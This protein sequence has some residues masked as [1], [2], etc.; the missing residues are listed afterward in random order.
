[1]ALSTTGRPDIIGRWINSG[2]KALPVIDD[3]PAFVG[4]WKRWWG[5]LQPKS[6][7]QKGNGKGSRGVDDKEEWEDLR[8]GSINGFFNIVVSLASWWMALKTAAQRKIFLEMIDEVSW[9]MDQMMGEVGAGKKRGHN[10]VEE[11]GSRKSKK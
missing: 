6:R 2:R 7:V 1:M 10:T 8:K 9:A 4:S 5:A 11:E 3:L